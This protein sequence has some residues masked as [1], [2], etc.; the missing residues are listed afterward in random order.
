MTV[1]KIFS[2][3]YSVQIKLML[4][5]ELQTAAIPSSSVFSFKETD[6]EDKLDYKGIAE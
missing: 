5:A 3:S 2:I 1:G 4:P 6:A